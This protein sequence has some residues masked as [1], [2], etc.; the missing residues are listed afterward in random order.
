MCAL[1]SLYKTLSTIFLISVP[2]FIVMLSVIILS[3]VAPKPNSSK[4]INALEKGV[5]LKVYLKRFNAEGPRGHSEN[6]YIDRQRNGS[7]VRMETF[8]WHKFKYSSN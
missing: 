4:I 5:F 1:Q 8:W 6:Q 7:A 3:V 2:F